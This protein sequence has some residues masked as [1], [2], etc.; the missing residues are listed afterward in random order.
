MVARHKKHNNKRNGTWRCGLLRF[1]IAD[2]YFSRRC[3]YG[4]G[5]VKARTIKKQFLKR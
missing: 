4:R 3:T 1:V 5:I 2:V